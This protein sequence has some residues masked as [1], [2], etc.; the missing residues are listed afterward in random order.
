VF[1]RVVRL[2]LHRTVFAQ[3]RPRVIPNQPHETINQPTNRIVKRPVLT[4]QI[5]VQHPP[6][7]VKKTGSSQPINSIQPR[8]PLKVTVL[9]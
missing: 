4:N 1:F 2:D 5:T 3:E 7:L 8:P 6:S 9:V